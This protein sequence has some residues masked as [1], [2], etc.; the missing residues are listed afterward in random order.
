MA[1]SRV[2]GKNGAVAFVTGC[3]ADLSAWSIRFVN[4]ADDDTSYADTGTGSS[5][6]GSGTLDY[7]LTTSGFLYK[8]T[9]T[10]APGLATSIT[11]TGGAVTL[12]AD[13]GCTEAMTAIL[14]GGGIDHRK[15]SGA[16]PV[17]YEGVNDG[18]LTETWA[19]S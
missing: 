9:T 15:R 6:I 3:N 16:I 12:T 4:P 13:T 8:G 10:S 11:A 17:S 14:T 18:D 7:N 1:K 2:G 19:T 5:H